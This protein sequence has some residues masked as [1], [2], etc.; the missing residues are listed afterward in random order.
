MTLYRDFER[1]TESD[2]PAA[3]AFREARA[4]TA[5][6][7]QQHYDTIMTLLGIVFDAGCRNGQAM[8]AE[9]LVQLVTAG[10]DGSD[11]HG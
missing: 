5:D 1:W 10:L 9:R 2:E 6:L 4:Q 7:S 3:V 8:A 11:D